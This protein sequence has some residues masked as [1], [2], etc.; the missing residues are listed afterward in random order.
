[1]NELVLATGGAEGVVELLCELGPE[2]F[3]VVGVDPEHGSARVLAEIAVSS[4]E[5]WS[6]AD[7][8]VGG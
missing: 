4:D 1:M 2:I 3:V 6:V 7:V 8:V 5:G